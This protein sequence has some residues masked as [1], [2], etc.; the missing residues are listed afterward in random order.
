VLP[1][2]EKPVAHGAV[3]EART[4][5]NVTPPSVERWIPLSP[6]TRSVAGFA[7]ST[8]ICQK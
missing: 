4:P 6:A 5:V 2:R 3:S 7:G 8:R 1:A